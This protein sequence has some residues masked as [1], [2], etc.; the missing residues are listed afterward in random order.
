[1]SEIAVA[2]LYAVRNSQAAA[3]ACPCSCR[4]ERD[5]PQS[6]TPTLGIIATT[7]EFCAGARGRAAAEHRSPGRRDARRR[8]RTISPGAS[9][10]PANPGRVQ[11]GE[12][13]FAAAAS[14][15]RKRSSPTAPAILRSGPGGSCVSAASSSSS[16]QRR[17]RWAIGFRR[18]SARSGC[19]PGPAWSSASLA[20]AIS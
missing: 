11:I 16:G 10:P 15:C 9:R 8:A 4:L 13:M 12:I 17:A 2:G 3:A 18:R 6:I 20:T 5:R 1:M 7:P 19:I 14:A